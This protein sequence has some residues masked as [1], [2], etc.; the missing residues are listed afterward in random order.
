MI[1]NKLA[2]LKS[3]LSVY[4]VCYQEAVKTKDLKRMILL[5][6]IL[7]DLRDEIGILEE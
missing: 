3:K 6:P 7:S 1:Y 2:A 5:G 4:T